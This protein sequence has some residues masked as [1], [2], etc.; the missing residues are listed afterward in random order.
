MQLSRLL[1]SAECN[2]KKGFRALHAFV[3]ALD[4]LERI[5]LRNVLIVKMCENVSSTPRKLTSHINQ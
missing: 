5:S 1:F 3:D 4:A 2:G